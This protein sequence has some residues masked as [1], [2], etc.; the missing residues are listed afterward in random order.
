MATNFLNGS[1]EHEQLARSTFLP[2]QYVSPPKGAG[3]RQGM[4]DAKFQ[5]IS[6]LVP[7]IKAGNILFL[8]NQHKLFKQS[9]DFPRAKHDDILDALAYAW[10]FGHR[11]VMQEAQDEEEEEQT[12]VPA[13]SELYS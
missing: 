2:I 1:L 11:A 10:M 9:F 4:S 3:A 13:Y 8:P 5:R 12:Y 6:A 7:N